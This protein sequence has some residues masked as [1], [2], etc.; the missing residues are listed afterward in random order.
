MYAASFFWHFILGIVIISAGS[1]R[2]NYYFQKS[3]CLFSLFS[4]SFCI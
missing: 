1:I 3:T 4:S 2:C